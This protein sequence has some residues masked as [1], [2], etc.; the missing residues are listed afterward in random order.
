MTQN[1]RDFFVKS[2]TDFRGNEDYNIRLITGRCYNWIYV[3]GIDAERI[4]GK[5][6]E[7]RTKVSWG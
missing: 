5:G 2:H 4:S 3:K 7:K 6:M 1:K